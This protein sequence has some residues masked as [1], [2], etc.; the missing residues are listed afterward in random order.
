LLETLETVKGFLSM[1]SVK[2]R[3]IRKVPGGFPKRIF[4]ASYQ[5]KPIR[6][7]TMRKKTGKKKVKEKEGG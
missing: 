4:S 3:R 2:E 1:G 6:K 5:Q 7:K